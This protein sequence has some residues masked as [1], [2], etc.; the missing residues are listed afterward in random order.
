[1]TTNYTDTQLLAAINSSTPITI[2]IIQAVLQKIAPKLLN[3]DT[4]NQTQAKYEPPQVLEVTKQQQNT[5]DQKMIELVKS[6]DIQR[7]TGQMTQVQMDKEIAT[8]NAQ[9]PN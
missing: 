4:G 9:T 7:I 1:M 3:L 8:F 6:L 2:E 5:D